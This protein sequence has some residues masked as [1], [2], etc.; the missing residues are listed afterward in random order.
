MIHRRTLLAASML[1]LAVPASVMAQD[2][3]AD[4]QYGKVR[5]V[6]SDGVHVFK[7]VPYGGSTAGSGR[8]RPPTAPAAWTGVRDALN[9]PPMCPQVTRALPAI[10]ASWTL[11]KVMSEDCL[12]LNVW[13]P[14]LRDGGKR[15]AMVWL[16]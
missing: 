14:A 16:H 7:G 5:G 2:V 1:G 4:T 11:D 15:P 10:F 3:V 9:F 12:A 13:T 8:F 6:S